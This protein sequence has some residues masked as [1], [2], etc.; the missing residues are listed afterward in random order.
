MKN[1][2]KYPPVLLIL[3]CLLAGTIS[4]G[5]LYQYTVNVSGAAAYTDVHAVATNLVRV[6]GALPSAV[7]G[8]GFNTSKCKTATSFSTGRSAVEFSLS[9]EINWQ[10]TLTSFSCSIRRDANGPKK[11]RLAYSTN[12]GASWVTNGTDYSI[13]TSSA[14]G[15]MTDI[16]WDIPDFTTSSAILL[17]VYCFNS[18]LTSG[19]VQLKNII[20]NG[21][22]TELDNDADGY[23]FAA[24]CD[25][26]N[27]AVYPEATEVC[28]S[29]DDDCDGDVDEGFTENIFYYDGDGDT[30]GDAA[31]TIS[32]CMDSVPDYAFMGFDCDDTNP[33]I[34]FLADE[35]ENGIDDDCDGY[36]DT[37]VTVEV[38]GVSVLIKKAFNIQNVNVYP[39]PAGKNVHLQFDDAVSG[40][41]V[42]VFVID[43]QGVLTA[44]YA[45]TLP[46]GESTITLELPD[47]MS[48]GIYVLNISA[49][50]KTYR[51]QLFVE[52]R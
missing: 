17:R 4:F 30:F 47:A 10:L 49:G 23:P 9:P 6:N 32:T 13:T 29:L 44:T 14:C 28:N 45:S 5:Q 52:G 19:T 37:V 39:N 26:T 20:I 1:I 8:D 48:A 43:M 46:Y 25:D 34:N 18:T 40:A 35:V 22:S 21:V 38:F 31:I 16:T 3:T 51:K 2:H 15:E 12:G 41:Y 24:D 7:C 50:G 36:V 11:Y 42:R 33:M 27:P